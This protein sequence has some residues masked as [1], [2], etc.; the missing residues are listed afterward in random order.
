MIDD[1]L[2]GL[3][4]ELVFGRLNNSKR[5]QLILRM[6]FGFIGFILAGFGCYHFA[7]ATNITQN[8]A[9]RGSMIAVFVFLGC[10]SLFNVALGRQ[11]R[12]PGRLFILSFIALFAVRILYG[13]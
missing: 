1:I 5:T 2:A 13:P 8:V 11:W 6:F 9:L 3:F 10:F 4:G 12:W 7:T